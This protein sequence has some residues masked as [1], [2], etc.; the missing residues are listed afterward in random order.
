[1][2]H[3]V[4]DWNHLLTL[5]ARP[6]VSCSVKASVPSPPLGT[7]PLEPLLSRLLSSDPQNRTCSL[8]S[9]IP[10][11][12]FPPGEAALLQP[13][14][15][16]V[17]EAQSIKAPSLLSPPQCA[18]SCAKP[19]TSGQW[20]AGTSENQRSL[21]TGVWRHIHLQSQH[22]GS[23]GRIDSKFQVNLGYSV[24]LQNHCFQVTLQMLPE[25]HSTSHGFRE[26]L[27]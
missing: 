27:E 6:S 8:S 15:P 19:A 4:P 23:T 22:L 1:M 17:S 20:Q 24:R 26:N 18:T 2:P 3:A 16:E 5:P 13:S 11:T 25:A 10:T 9:A 14:F 21:K 7:G 12:V